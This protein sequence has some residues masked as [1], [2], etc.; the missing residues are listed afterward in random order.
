M[1]KRLFVLVAVLVLTVAAPALAQEMMRPD[2]L[3][4]ATSGACFEEINGQWSYLLVDPE[5]DAWQ[6]NLVGDINDFFMINPS[7]PEGEV[8]FHVQD[9]QA[10]LFACRAA[11]FPACV[12]TGEGLLA[13]TGLWMTTGSMVRESVFLVCPSMTKSTGILADVFTGERFKINVTLIWSEQVD[14]AGCGSRDT[15]EVFDISIR[16]LP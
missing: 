2:C 6:G 4:G 15:P 9:N 3:N 7:Y 10:S 11:D 12:S 5:G 8:L 16:A 14:G 13:G 1:R